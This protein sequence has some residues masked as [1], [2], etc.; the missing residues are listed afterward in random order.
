[1]NVLNVTGNLSSQRKECL[2]N[3][4]MRARKLTALGFSPYAVREF[5]EKGEGLEVH[6]EE[7]L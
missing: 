6:N 3:N 4:C 5:L 2:C 7:T 1:M